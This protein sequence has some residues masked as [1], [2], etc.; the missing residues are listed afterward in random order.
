MSR[1]PPPKDRTN[2]LPMFVGY[3]EVQSALGVS[4]RTIERMVR[5]GRFPRPI[6]LAPNRVGWQVEVVEGWLS[7]SGRRLEARAVPRPEDLTPEVLIEEATGLIAEALSRKHG[8]EIGTDEIDSVHV[9]RAI[10][11]QEFMAS[12]V[13][14]LELYAN[15]FQ[16]FSET[17][18]LILAAWLFASIRPY[19]AGE[20]GAP[21]PFL[22]DP[23]TLASFGPMALHDETWAELEAQLLTQQTKRS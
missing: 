15:R 19:F 2:L 11:E 5:E 14:E 3:R 4:R 9:S 22:N 18:A 20:D 13:Q 17:R 21:H 12:E 10:T 16:G 6:Q 1:Q 23:E 7:E 8:V